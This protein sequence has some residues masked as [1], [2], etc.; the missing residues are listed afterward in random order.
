MKEKYNKKILSVCSYGEVRSV[1]MAN[2][3]KELGYKDVLTVG[4]AEIIPKFFEKLCDEHD[5]ILICNRTDFGEDGKWKDTKP[6]FKTWFSKMMNDYNKK[7]IYCE[8]GNDEWGDPFN[9]KL[10]LKAR[11]IANKVVKSNKMK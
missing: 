4:T 1:A 11:K 5:I 7:I 8:F 6:E 10:V 9:P 3:M 2:A